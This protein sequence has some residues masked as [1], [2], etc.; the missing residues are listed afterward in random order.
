MMEAAVLLYPIAQI[1]TLQ[2]AQIMEM[3]FVL[4]VLALNLKT[5]VQML[6]VVLNKHH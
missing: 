6:W 3:F 4:M 2:F 1:I 5:D